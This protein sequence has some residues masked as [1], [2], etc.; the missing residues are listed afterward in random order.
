MSL[1]M[2]SGLKT[3]PCEIPK[4]MFAEKDDDL[5]GVTEAVGLG[6]DLSYH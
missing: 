2:L 1:Q 4:V 5:H 6:S 3:M